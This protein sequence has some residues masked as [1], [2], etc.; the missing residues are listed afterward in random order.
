MLKAGHR[1]LKTKMLELF[2]DYMEDFLFRSAV[3]DLG[4]FACAFSGFANFGLG[5]QASVPPK[6]PP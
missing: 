1:E 6:A 4:Y 2:E 5:S 3:L